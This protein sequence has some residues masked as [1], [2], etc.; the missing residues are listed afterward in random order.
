MTHVGGPTVGDQAVLP[1]DRSSRS[2]RYD[3][4][5]TQYSQ[6]GDFYDF[7]SGASFSVSMWFRIDPNLM[8]T[9]YFATYWLLSPPL[10][11]TRVT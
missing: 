6:A 1:N 7:D 4:S 10:G 8:F 9:E 11:R 5:T 3:G 2:V